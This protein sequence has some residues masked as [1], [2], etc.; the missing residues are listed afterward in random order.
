MTDPIRTGTVIIGSGFSGLGMGI[1]LK[2]DGHDDF[3]ILEKA[4]EV[5]GTW[6]DNTYP[7]A[8]C[9]VPTHLYS[10]SFEPRSNWKNLWSYQPEI[11]DYLREVAD[12]YQVRRHVQFH[13][14]AERGY[15]DAEE[16]RWHLFTT[17][18]QEYV[19]Q[20]V[21]S[22]IGALHIP[23]IPSFT[24]LD[25]FA[26]PAFHSAEW[27][28][29][30]DLTGKRVAVIGTGASAVQF[31][32]EI[33]DEVG[34][35]QL[36][37]RTPPWVLPRQNA[38]IPESVQSAF[39][40]VPG[41]RKTFR[42]GLYWG[43]EAG[44]YAM[45]NRP[46]LLKGVELVGKRFI[47]SQI[48]DPE[49]RRKLT[50]DYRAGCKRL[51]GSNTY[52]RALNQPKSQVITESIA[53]V[54][55]TGI[56]TADG[57]EHAADVIIFGTGFHVTDSFESLSIKGA[58]GADLVDRFR[59][60]GPQAHRGITVADMPNAFFLLGPNTGLGHTSIVFM[61]ESQI[62]YVSQAI[63]QV[64]QNR[65]QALVPRRAVQAEYNYDL[66]RRLA[67]SVWNTG[68]CS[69]W[70]LD[71]HGNNRTLWPGYTW[72]YWLSTRNVRLDEYELLGAA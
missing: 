46:A 56:V 33:I 58:D 21:V 34:E 37:Q 3:V 70:Y 8:A 26:G 35:L 30:V 17:D 67:R 53:R 54:T 16:M 43:A 28:H 11:F 22:A 62:H 10:Y 24:G 36:Y 48:D 31:V 68:G 41:L 57:I 9:D 14:V 66:Q 38:P 45:N 49:L 4:G 65:V 27:D 25:E 60:E 7:G 72:R 18:G 12:K 47:K 32:P 51:L 42:N 50:P 23:S 44:A 20:F 29:N 2:T 52:Y 5:G 55:A 64:R 39:A 15:W 13:K 61:I 6:R 19:A 63:R 71:A 1:A 40:A 69:S 59:R